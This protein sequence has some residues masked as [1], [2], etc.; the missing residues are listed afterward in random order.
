MNVLII[1]QYFPPDLGGAAT[2][3]YNVAKGLSLN[4]CNVTVITA[5]PHY[6]HGKIPQTYRWKPYKIEYM[7]GL[8]VI[9]TFMPSIKS[10]GF[11][12]RLVL[13][14]AFAI[15]SLFVLP[16][17]NNIDSIWASSWIPGYIYSR[18][19]K[20]RL[21]LNVDDLT[22]EDLA[23]LKIINET[24][25]FFKIAS[26]I[27]RLFYI[28]ADVLTPISKGYYNIIENKYRVKLKKI[29]LVRGGV[30]LS[31]F[32]PAKVIYPPESKKFTVLY[33]GAF[34][35]AYD[36]DQVFRAAKL[37]QDTD[38]DIQ[39]V[40]QGGGE[41][42]D[43]MQQSLKGL[44]ITNVHIIDA[45][46]SRKEVAEQLALADVLLLPLAPFSASGEPYRGMSS[47]IYEYQ[48]VG[49]P[50][51]CCGEGVTSTYVEKETQ[52]GLTVKSGD[53]KNL[54]QSVLLLKQNPSLANSIGQNGRDYVVHEAAIE[55]I[56]LKIKEL[57]SN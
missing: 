17:I 45:I 28:K 57:L 36:F 49:K 38:P 31:I 32:K 30:D 47:K 1:A 24:S 22:L 34:S 2:R 15:T 20:R 7:S 52:S 27:Y 6:P 39:I 50:I 56:G 10:K 14:S 54:A 42:L 5:F 21:A 19:K 40:I 43:S 4:G 16:L 11:F 53:F 8:R 37:L 18:F 25:F 55:V 41:L 26:N 29:H 51:I 35:V 3:A 33:S 9:R 44:K 23:D 12:K 46:L 48:A 13:R